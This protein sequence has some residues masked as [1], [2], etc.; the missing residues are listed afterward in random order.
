ML[1]RNETNENQWKCQ[2]DISIDD[3]IPL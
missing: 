1:S 3:K 2:L